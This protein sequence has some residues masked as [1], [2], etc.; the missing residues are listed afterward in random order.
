MKWLIIGLLMG[1][2][3]AEPV[4][5]SVAKKQLIRYH[6]SGQYEQDVEKAIFNATQLLKNN[7]SSA[8]LQQ[9]RKMAVV[10]D[11]D[12]T[13]LSNYPSMLALNFG[14]TW[15]MINQTMYRISPVCLKAS[16]QLYQW[17]SSQGVALFF[18]TARP[19]AFRADTEK[20]LNQLGYHGWHYVY[21]YPKHARTVGMYKFKIRRMLK[22]KGFTI[23]ANIGDQRVDFVGGIGMSVKIP[24]PFYEILDSA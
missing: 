5:L 8:T 4:N 23:I 7:L 17:L 15:T 2:A 13:V 14:G 1:H 22:E 20:Q 24:N 21:M 12:E 11:I 19:E 6:D 16:L 3:I 9:R 10:F 18:I